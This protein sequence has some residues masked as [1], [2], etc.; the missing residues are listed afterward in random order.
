M[1]LFILNIRVSKHSETY[2]YIFI[3]S[4]KI[5]S[6]MD[7]DSTNNTFELIGRDSFN[8]DNLTSLFGH[9]DDALDISTQPNKNTSIETESGDNSSYI[10]YK[11]RNSINYQDGPES[12]SYL[13]AMIGVYA[14][15]FICVMVGHVTRKKTPAEDENY[16]RRY[17]YQE[18]QSTT[19]R[20]LR[21]FNIKRIT[22]VKD[23]FLL[24]H[25]PEEII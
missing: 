12:V 4:I 17:D 13:I 16:V 7:G 5:P 2:E 1:I 10:F 8:S 23:G 15:I 22:T 11:Y 19:A 24:D 3:A 21:R 14:L 9:I 6:N 20:A 25:V 18:I